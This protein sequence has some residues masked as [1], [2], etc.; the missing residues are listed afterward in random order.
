MSSCDAHTPLCFPLW[1]GHNERL[2]FSRRLRI[3]FT[4]IITESGSPNWTRFCCI[5]FSRVPLGNLSFWC[6][7][8]SCRRTCS[9]VT[10]LSTRVLRCDNDRGWTKSIRTVVVLERGLGDTTGYGSSVDL[11]FRWQ[12]ICCSNYFLLGY[13]LTIWFFLSSYCIPSHRNAA[14]LLS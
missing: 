8:A 14:R 11:D 9:S 6:F 3:V 12:S 4:E 2:P 7:F 5:H 13:W 10:S 1:F